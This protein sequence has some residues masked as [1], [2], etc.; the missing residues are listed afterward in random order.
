MEGI[1]D[2]NVL[3]I[4]GC[5]PNFDPLSHFIR[6]LL[7]KMK[8]GCPRGP[9]LAGHPV[10]ISKTIS[11]S[12]SLFENFCVS[13]VSLSLPYPMPRHITLFRHRSLHLHF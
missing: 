2:Q 13:H 12:P 5:S 8:S 10:D 3:E 9:G 1:I 6:Q 4:C 7:G 11:P